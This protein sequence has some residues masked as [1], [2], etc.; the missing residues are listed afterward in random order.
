MTSISLCWRRRSTISGFPFKTAVGCNK[1][2][3]GEFLPPNLSAEKLDCKHNNP[4]A[5]LVVQNLPVDMSENISEN[6]N[7]ILNTTR[8]QNRTKGPSPCPHRSKSAF[9]TFPPCLQLCAV[10]STCQSLVAWLPV[11]KQVCAESVCPKCISLNSI[12]ALKVKRQ[13]WGSVKQAGVMFICC[14]MET[15]QLTA[16]K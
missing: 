14:P 6:E 12:P 7:R 3:R 2:F 11:F 16:S 5:I 10:D 4:N 1:Y 15:D 13:F 8:R 9:T